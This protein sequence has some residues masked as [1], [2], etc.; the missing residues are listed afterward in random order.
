MADSF[1][2]PQ[3]SPNINA[4]DGH[5]FLAQ[6]VGSHKKSTLITG[7]LYCELGAIISPSFFKVK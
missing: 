7:A 1:R 5:L 4:D 6:S 2:C 3:E